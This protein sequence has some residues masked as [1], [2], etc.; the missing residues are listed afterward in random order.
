MEARL[1]ESR[2]SLLSVL[3]CSSCFL[4]QDRRSMT[5]DEHAPG[6]QLPEAKN[7]HRESIK[8]FRVIW[9]DGKRQWVQHCIP[10]LGR[11]KHYLLSTILHIRFRAGTELSYL[12]EKQLS[13][14]S[15]TLSNPKASSIRGYY[16]S[17][18]HFRV[19]R[20]PCGTLGHGSSL[21]P[22]SCIH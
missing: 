10:L 1:E 20:L 16:R 14:Y 21:R 22:Q 18:S 5:N 7:S 12:L 19:L 3:A 6:R 9:L 4:W 17:V 8:S 2:C 13:A 15:S 11:L